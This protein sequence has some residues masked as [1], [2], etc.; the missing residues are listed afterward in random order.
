MQMSVDRARDIAKQEH[1]YDDRSGTLTAN[2]ISKPVTISGKMITGTVA[3]GSEVALYIHEGTGLYGPKKQAY[4]IKPV[5]AKALAWE[6]PASGGDLSGGAGE[7]IFA[8]RVMHPGIKPDPFLQKAII[9]VEP[10][11]KQK[12]KEAFRLAA[13]Q[14]V[15]GK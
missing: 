12:L 8:K 3:N 10:F 7:L 9:K 13:Q 15:G 14:S 1:E 4:E 6:T 11:M 2:T 5:D